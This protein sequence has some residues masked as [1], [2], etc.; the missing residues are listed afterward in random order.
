MTRRWPGPA[1]T[2][3]RLCARRRTR[4]R[5]AE[6]GRCGQDQ[7]VDTVAEASAFRVEGDAAEVVADFIQLLGDGLGCGAAEIERSAV[8]GESGESFP[9]AFAFQQGARKE[10]VLPDFVDHDVGSIVENFQDILGPL[11]ESLPGG[12]GGV[13]DEVAGRVP[14]RVDATRDRGVC[15]GVEGFQFRPLPDQCSAVRTPH[16]K[17]QVF[18]IALVE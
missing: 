14:V 9:G 8:R 18:G 16:M 2:S 11:V 15:F 12:V 6:T 4:A 7:R 13:C 3:P 5:D 1:G 17:A 10:P